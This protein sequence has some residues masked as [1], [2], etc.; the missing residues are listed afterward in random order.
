MIQEII[1]AASSALPHIGETIATVIAVLGTMTG[2]DYYKKRKNGN[3]DPT[4]ELKEIKEVLIRVEAGTDRMTDAIGNLFNDNN[5]V[6]SVM[7]NMRTEVVKTVT[8][9]RVEVAKLD[10]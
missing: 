10:K 3:T 6:I 7:G 5:R 8:D 4:K 9:L 2:R 1:D